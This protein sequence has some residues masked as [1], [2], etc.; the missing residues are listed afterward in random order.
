MPSESDSIPPHALA[1]AESIRVR[2]EEMIR[3]ANESLRV[4]A[5]ASDPGT[6]SSKS[7]LTRLYI[8]RLKSV[9]DRYPFLKLT[10]L[11]EFERCLTEI[12]LK[13]SVL[14]ETADE[15]SSATVSVPIRGQPL[16]QVTKI[17]ELVGGQI[18]LNKRAVGFDVAALLTN[19][20][21]CCFPGPKWML[22]L[23]I[24][25]GERARS[26]VLELEII[27]SHEE[28]E[29][30]HAEPV[31]LSFYD[32]RS[33]VLFRDRLFIPER[34]VM[35]VEERE[36]VVMR[37]KKVVYDEEF[38][39]AS[40][41]AAVSNQEA[42]VEFQNNRSKRDVIPEHVKMLVWTRDGRSCVRCGTSEKLQFD[43]VI[44]VAKGGSSDSANIQ[45]LCQ[46]CN[47]KKSDK[48]VF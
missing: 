12:E 46:P 2:A 29:L 5:E 40:I 33:P 34:R 48:I 41:R 14:L 37:A 24:G 21:D 13:T 10:S 16:V 20:E 44:P 15:P 32:G 39:I 22:P 1:E 45:L 18:V 36:Q 26:I 43:H 38:E 19:I 42:T 47:L 28:Y 11:T 9:A 4:A 23:T 27:L 6:R 25:K 8:D 7:K 17:G 35:T 31:C 3:I 30:S